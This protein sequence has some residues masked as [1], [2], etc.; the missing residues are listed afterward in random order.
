MKIR[1]YMRFPQGR[2]KA[3]TLSYDDGVEQDIR[4]MGIMDRYGIKGT[5]NLNSEC[6]SA[7]GT[8]FSQGQIHRRMTRKEAVQLYGGTVHEV[9]AHTATHPFLETLPS[10]AVIHEI[11]TDRKNLEDDFGE[12]VRGMALPFGTYS[13]S[14]IEILRECGIVYA[15]T[16]Q[17]TGGFEM[18]TD[19][20]RLAATC[21]HRDPNL[22]NL[23]ETFVSMEVKNKPKLF[24]LWGHSYEFEEDDNW[25]LMEAFCKYTGGQKDIWYATNLEIYE[26][27]EAYNRLIWSVGLEKVYNPSAMPVWIQFEIEGVCSDTIKIEAGTT[28]FM[29]I[30]R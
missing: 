1:T 25:S 5:F 8:A 19:W 13:D 20:L 29:P 18:P 16:T 27:W 12:I 30:H 21:R 17:S 9:A 11:L 24:Y 10:V 2:G 22:M 14:V 23:A 28:A 15:R 6:Y 26:Y 7:E 4:L 3:L